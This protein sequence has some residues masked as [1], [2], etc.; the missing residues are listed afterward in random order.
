MILCLFEDVKK[1]Q[2]FLCFPFKAMF[3]FVLLVP[4]DSEAK[5]VMM[6]TL[7]KQRQNMSTPILVDMS[8]I[9]WSVIEL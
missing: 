8:L 7:N 6:F 9:T 4:I 2:C 3:H 5:F 1:L